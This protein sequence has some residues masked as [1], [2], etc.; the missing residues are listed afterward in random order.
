MNESLTHASSR[1]IRRLMKI[2]LCAALAAALFWSQVGFGQI[3][4]SNSGGASTESIDEL[5]SQAT[6][7][8]SA[9]DYD[10]AFKMADR[11]CQ[12]NPK[13]IRQQLFLG[14]ISFAAGK[15]DECIA[16]Y[17]AAIAI[18]PA[19]APRL[20]Q[21]G[22]ALYYAERFADGVKQ[23]ETHQTVN[24]QDVENAVWHLLCESR[25]S[26]LPQARKKLIQISDDPRVPMSEIYEM[27]AGRMTPEQVSEAADSTSAEVAEGSR[28]HKLQYYF[29]WLYIGL[30]QE[31]LGQQETAVE[32]MKKAEE[33]NPLGKTNF[34][35]QVA[36]IHL[37]RSA[38]SPNKLQETKP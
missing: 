7:A 5:M 9:G 3:V 2:S 34:M 33:Y 15:I 21:R 17:D 31:M 29:A 36:R 28:Q 35:G 1:S 38:A 16:A 11:V 32:S 23:F 30:Y 26:D 8:F 14:Q 37:H 4:E 27:F 18:Q 12:L 13:D 22:L 10:Q 6:K 25:I 20:W 24:P 19:I